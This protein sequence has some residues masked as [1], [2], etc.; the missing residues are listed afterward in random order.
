MLPPPATAAR[1]CLINGLEHGITVPLDTR[2]RL[3][4]QNVFTI[5]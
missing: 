5:S 1:L 3:W 2:Q 4:P